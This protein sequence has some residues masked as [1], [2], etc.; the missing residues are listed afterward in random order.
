MKGLPPPFPNKTVL[1]KTLERNKSF[2]KASINEAFKTSRY[3]VIKKSVV[4]STIRAYH[5]GIYEPSSI[6]RTWSQNVFFKK[7]KIETLLKSRDYKEFDKVH[8]KLERS[9]NTYWRKKA[10]KELKVC[11]SCK[12][13]DL[14]LKMV[15][16]FSEIPRRSKNKL[17]KH[18]H[19]PLDK[20][21][22]YALR[23]IWNNH[24]E[25]NN[26][27]LKKITANPSMSFIGDDYNL[28]M[29]IQACIRISVKPYNPIEFDFAVWNR[30]ETDS[31][32]FD[33]KFKKKSET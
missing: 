28:Y 6:F 16:N 8:A 13:L 14:L 3:L 4:G 21:T 1:L 20:Y 33:L 18:L 10:Q 7:G 31:L 23:N 26:N 5:G 24:L 15:I 22:L 19:V 17:L 25:S 9:L 30:Q 12:L 27:E 29:E 2:Y 11:Y 32:S